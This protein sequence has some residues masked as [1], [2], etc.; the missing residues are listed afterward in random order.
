MLD[1]QKA[2]LELNRYWTLSETFENGM[3]LFDHWEG[4][5]NLCSS[6]LNEV[7]YLKNTYESKSK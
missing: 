4:M 2:R 1:I 3:W 7:M 6:L 5:L